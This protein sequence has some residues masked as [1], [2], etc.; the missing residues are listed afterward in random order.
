MI[1]PKE[2]SNKDVNLKTQMMI[3][4]TDTKGES[5]TEQ[6]W[7]EN[8]FFNDQRTDLIILKGNFPENTLV[9]VN[10]GTIAPVK[11]G[12]AM[13]VEFVILAQIMPVANPPPD[14]NLDMD[15][16]QENEGLLYVPYYNTENGLCRGLTKKLGHIT[17]RGNVNEQFF[18]LWV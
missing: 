17:L 1:L 13:Y 8:D 12:H 16:F 4:M 3:S 9:C 11:G 7:K 6:V 14:L 10:N 15:K 5:S 2:A 18:S